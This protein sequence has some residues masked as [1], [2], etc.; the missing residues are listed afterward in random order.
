MAPIDVEYQPLQ[1]SYEAFFTIAL[2]DSEILMFQICELE[3]L[4][5]VH[6]VQHSQ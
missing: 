4:D 1:K 2:T 5:Q 3:N 6:E